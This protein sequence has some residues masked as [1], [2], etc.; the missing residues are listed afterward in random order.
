MGV[1]EVVRA[2]QRWTG[3]GHFQMG[4]SLCGWADLRLQLLWIFS[5]HWGRR[6]SE[7]HVRQLLCRDHPGP[8]SQLPASGPHPLSS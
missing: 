8:R 6:D 3:M 1:L 2:D 5:D 7:R 4:D